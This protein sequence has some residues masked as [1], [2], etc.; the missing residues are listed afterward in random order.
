MILV[1][2]LFNNSN[3]AAE[4][5]QLRWMEMLMLTFSG[6]YQIHNYNDFHA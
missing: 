5:L 4:Q 6:Y 1:L 3:T 2:V